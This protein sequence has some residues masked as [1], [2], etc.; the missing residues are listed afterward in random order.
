MVILLMI[1][2]GYYIISYCWLLY[3]ILQLLMI[4]VL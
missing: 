2:N 3:V 1:I 4:I